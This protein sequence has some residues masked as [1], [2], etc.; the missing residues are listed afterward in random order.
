MLNYFF[1][2]DINVVIVFYY[3]LGFENDDEMCVWYFDIILSN[4]KVKK[5]LFKDDFKGDIFLSIVV[6]ESKY[7][8]I[9]SMLK[10]FE[11]GECIVDF[12]N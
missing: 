6:S 3:F 2:K 10:F 11:S 7:S 1:Y 8:R 4:E 5:C 12:L 9:W